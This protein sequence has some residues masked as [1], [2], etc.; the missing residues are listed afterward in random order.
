MSKIIGSV[1]LILFFF[2]PIGAK[3]VA[4]AKREKQEK[5]TV[6]VEFELHKKNVVVGEFTPWSARVIYDPYIFEI[7]NV[8]FPGADRK[9]FLEPFKPQKKREKVDGRIRETVEWSGEYFPKRVGKIEFKPFSV[10][11]IK[12]GEDRSQGGVFS[13]FGVFN[14]PRIHRIL[15]GYNFLFVEPLPPGQRGQ[16]QVVGEFNDFKL[17][18]DRNELQRGD[19]GTLTLEIKGKGN[20][21]LFQPKL[22]L[23]ESLRCYSSGGHST[24]EGAIFEYVVQPVRAGSHLIPE[25]LLT[26]FDTKTRSYK[27]LSTDQ[28]RLEVFDREFAGEYEDDQL[29]IEAFSDDKPFE[30][31]AYDGSNV[32]M[33]RVEI[34]FLFFILLIIVLA[35]TAFFVRIWSRLCDY[36]RR[37]Y[38]W[39]SFKYFILRAKSVLNCAC[40]NES[41]TI[42]Y[43]VFK[44]IEEEVDLESAFESEPDRFSSWRFFWEE[45]SGMVFAPRGANFC[46]NDFLERALNWIDYIKKIK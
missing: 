13:M 6:T 15:S 26:Y 11:Y 29:D 45:V 31:K 30:E 10:E 2:I 27:K 12:R 25:Q 35:S 22:Q 44:R 8:S 20:I 21:H 3:E 36:S 28:V 16:V 4:V 19:A 32:I 39:I 17:D 23:P 33:R 24:K 18:V 42:I 40:K 38:G 41:G 1:F 37:I 14:Q 34:P 46:S 5:S 7:T 43:S 9:N